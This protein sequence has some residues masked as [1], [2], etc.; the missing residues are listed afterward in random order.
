MNTKKLST[1]IIHEAA[2]HSYKYKESSIV[3]DADLSK[4]ETR[5]LAA[6]LFVALKKIAPLQGQVY[7]LTLEIEAPEAEEPEIKEPEKKEE[8]PEKEDKKESDEE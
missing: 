4:K 5:D 6:K 7:K 3:I 1:Q 8:E 2:E